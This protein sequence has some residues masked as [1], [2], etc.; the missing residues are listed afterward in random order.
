MKYFVAVFI[1]AVVVFLGATVYYKGIPTFPKYSGSSVSTQSGAPGVSEEMSPSP[2]ASGSATQA[3]DENISI[4]SAVQAAL[5]TEHGPDAANLNITI[6]KVEGDYAQGDASAQGGGS[7]WFAA[8]V[9]GE[10]ILVWDGNG[11]INCSD[12]ASYSAIPVDMIS[13]C[14]DTVAQKTVKR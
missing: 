3:A 2:Q 6:S 5:V 14:W 9:N 10:W 12:I 1:T 4:V 8:K 13:E 7:I 11:Q